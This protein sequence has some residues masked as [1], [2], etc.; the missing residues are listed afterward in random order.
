MLGAK[1]TKKSRFPL[2]AFAHYREL[3]IDNDGD[4]IAPKLR[5]H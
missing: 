3:P 4:S 2:K 1:C 5:T